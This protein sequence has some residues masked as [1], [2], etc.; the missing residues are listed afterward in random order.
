MSTM[1][2][3]AIKAG[4]GE[5]AFGFVEVLELTPSVLRVP[6]WLINSGTPGPR[7][8]VTAGV[9]GTEYAGIE[10][11][12]RVAR[13]TNPADLRG[14]LVVFPVINVLGFETADAFTMPIDGEN[15]NRLFPGDAN[16]SPGRV[17]AHFIFESVRRLADAAVDLH[18]GNSDQGLCTPFSVYH[19]TGGLDVDRRSKE[20]ARLLD[21]PVTWAIDAQRYGAML[22]CALNRVG[23]PAAIGE[24]GD[25]GLCREADV[26][27][28]LRGVA[29]ILKHLGAI[30]G[31]PETT[32]ASPLE[33]F[34]RDFFIVAR[35][36]GVFDA[37]FPAGARARAGDSLGEIKNLA[38]DTVEE[39]TCPYD[40]V[41]VSY[42]SARVVHPGSRLYHGLVV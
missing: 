11:A 23:I 38:G 2:I 8:A 31:V 30:E 7:V 35:R 29:N 17:L 28:H 4:P 21:A 33:I 3:G 16:G 20:M 18:G 10:A 19:E 12:T 42:Q 34:H 22:T 37:R 39:V 15:V 25:L 5:K 32:Q 26:E 1:A 13:R 27:R 41:L 14:T 40:G 6:V 24:A 36:G 9:H